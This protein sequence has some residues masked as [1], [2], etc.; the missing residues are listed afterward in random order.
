MWLYFKFLQTNIL[1]ER[2]KQIY[3]FRPN[4]K[5]YYSKYR[6]QISVIRQLSGYHYINLNMLHVV[7]SNSCPVS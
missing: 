5:F 2:Q 3:M 1:S 7:H 6:Q 4:T